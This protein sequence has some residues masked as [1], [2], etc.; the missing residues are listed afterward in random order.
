MSGSGRR[1]VFSV[2]ERIQ[3]RSALVVGGV[4]TAPFASVR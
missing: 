4:V 3:V 2:V 1:N